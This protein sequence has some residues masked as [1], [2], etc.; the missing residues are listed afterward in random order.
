MEGSIFKIIT[1][2]EFNEY[3]W[4]YWGCDDQNQPITNGE[5]GLVVD[6]NDKVIYFIVCDGCSGDYSIFRW[7]KLLESM[8]KAMKEYK[9]AKK[10]ENITDPP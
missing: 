5:H 10:H 8:E 7:G 4:W 6:K 9:K 2:E 1:E 3:S